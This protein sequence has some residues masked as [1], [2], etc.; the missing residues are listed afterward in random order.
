VAGLQVRPGA[1][2]LDDPHGAG[3]E[4]AVVAAEPRLQPLDR[5]VVSDDNK[6]RQAVVRLSQHLE[7]V[8]RPG[9]VEI[10]AQVHVRDGRQPLGNDLESLP[11]PHGR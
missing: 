3:G 9:V 10:V 1:L 8:I 5:G 11:G 2:E 7:Q 6:H 4:A